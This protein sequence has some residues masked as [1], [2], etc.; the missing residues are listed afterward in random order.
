MAPWSV[1]THLRSQSSRP[2]P[3]RPPGSWPLPPHL[4]VGQW[5]RCLGRWRGCTWG[6]GWAQVRAE[7]VSGWC[8]VVCDVLTPP[9]TGRET[10]AQLETALWARPQCCGP[11]LFPASPTP[12]R[13][14][15]ARWGGASSP[16]GVGLGVTTPIPSHWRLLDLIPLDEAAL[17]LVQGL[18]GLADGTVQLPRGLELLHVL[19]E[20]EVVEGAWDSQAQVTGAQREAS[21]LGWGLPWPLFTLPPPCVSWATQPRERGART[22][23]PVSTASL[24]MA[25]PGPGRGG[26]AGDRGSAVP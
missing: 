5:A 23:A 18:E 26:R 24:A 10:E 6:Q 21:A 25:G 17:V 7:G 8:P 3:C 2:H 15:G 14:A 9:F 13:P 22:W 16:T 11:R 4:S 20:L 12:A 19:Q 1:L